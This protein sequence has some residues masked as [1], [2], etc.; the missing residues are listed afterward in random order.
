MAKKKTFVEKSKKLSPIGIKNISGKTKWR[1]E[2]LWIV[3]ILILTFISF[4]P[5]IK[6]RFISW[7]D[8]LY[9]TESNLIKNLSFENIKNIFS[10]SQAVALNYHPLTVLSFGI[11]YHFSKLNPFHYH[12]V[13]LLIHLLNTLLVFIFVYRLSKGKLIAGLFVSLFFGIHPM[14]VES[15]TW[16]SERKDVLYT[17]FFIAA[18]ISYIKYNETKKTKFIIFTFFLFVL[19]VLSKAMAV[20]L[21]FAMFLID[22]Y[23][24]RKVTTKVIVEKIP[25]FIISLLFGLLAINIQS[26]GAIASYDT[27]TLFQRICFGFFGFFTYIWKMFLPVNLSSFYPYPIAGSQIAFPV[28]FYIPVFCGMILFILIGILSFLKPEKMKLFTFGTGFYFVTIVFVLQFLSVGQVIMADRYSYIPYIGLLFPIGMLLNDFTERKPTIKSRVIIII[29]AIAFIFSYMT[30]E[31]T[32]VWKNT[33]TLWTDVIDQYPYPPWT[34][35]IAYVGRGKYYAAE[36]NDIDKA[37]F[38]FNT[39]LLMKTKNPT[40]YNNLGNI[41]GVKGQEFEK[42]GD[43]VKAKEIYNK[44][45]EYFAKSMSLDSNSENTYMNRATAYIYMKKY[46]LAAADFNRALQ[47]DPQNID[48]LEKR[49]YAYY[50]SKK[51]KQAIMDYDILISKT[52]DKTYMFQYRGFAR[53]NLEMYREAITDFNITIQ[54]EPQNGYAYYYLSL[55]YNHLNDNPAAINNL[56]KAIQFGYRVDQGSPELLNSKMK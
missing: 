29:V 56:D 30:H 10:T 40:V 31:R 39:L 4:Y 44:S 37:L 20:V 13:N 15:V 24:G 12:L 35:E 22:Y 47:F 46:D 8:P 50:K 14:H 55:C 34:I 19:S 48:Y 49:A 1:S 16:I 38:D 52:P 51:W 43:S 23:Q 36:I 27:F 11:D 21:P 17:F 9:I 3:A 7:D 54:R 41:Y 18:L 25:F 42:T 32:R 45:I 6:C 28:S 33:E 5:S 26:K 2:W 53:L